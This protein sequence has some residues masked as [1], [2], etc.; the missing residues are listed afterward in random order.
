[1]AL[2]R[3]INWKYLEKLAQASFSF[4]SKV[5]LILLTLSEIFTSTG[6]ATYSIN[7][8]PKKDGPKT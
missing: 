5:E 4:S 8:V 7:K 1:M 6:P 2:A 3:K